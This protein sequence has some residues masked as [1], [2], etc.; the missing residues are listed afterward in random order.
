[1]LI[2]QVI[3]KERQ[4]KFWHN[5]LVISSFLV[6]FL[7]ILFSWFYLFL[8]SGYLP[9]IKG[10]YFSIL[11]ISLVTLFVNYFFVY[12]FYLEKENF[13]FNLMIFSTLIIEI[14]FLICIL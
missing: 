9:G 4:K 10:E 3:K 7:I 5:K 14:I 13:L 11:I 2:N 8:R 12:K 6:N 1:M